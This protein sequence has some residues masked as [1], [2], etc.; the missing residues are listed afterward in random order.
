MLFLIARRFGIISHRQEGRFWK[1]VPKWEKGDYQGTGPYGKSP[2]LC[3]RTVRP[4][5]GA[6]QLTL[7]GWL[8]GVAVYATVS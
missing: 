8:W 3:I 5:A 1:L 7:P 4:L 2:I 6:A